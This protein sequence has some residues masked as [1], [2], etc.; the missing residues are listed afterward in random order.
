M[1]A[2]RSY[3]VFDLFFRSTPFMGSYAVFAGLEPALHYLRELRF[4]AED[5]AYLQI[6]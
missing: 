1:Y 2:I 4:A 6:V 5:L 3:Y